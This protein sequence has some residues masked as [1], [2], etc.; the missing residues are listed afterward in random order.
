MTSAGRVVLDR[1]CRP[2]RRSPRSDHLAYVI[3]TSG[4]TGEPKGVW[5]YVHRA[6]VDR[7]HWME[8]YA[9]VAADEVFCQ[10]TT[11]AF[12]DHVA[13]IFQ[14]HLRGGPCG[15]IPTEASGSAASG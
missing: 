14:P 11:I 7:V 5:R 3:Y 2:E 6:M 1:I 12:V 10:K 4:S 9:P 15:V 13:E 8:R